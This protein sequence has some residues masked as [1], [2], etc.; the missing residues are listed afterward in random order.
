[1]TGIL[2]A[3][4]QRKY[5]APDGKGR[6]LTVSVWGGPTEQ[7]FLKAVVPVFRALTGANVVFETGSGGERFNKLLAQGSMAT[8]DVFVNSGENVYQA[9]RLGKLLNVDPSLVPNLEDIA[10]WAKLFPYGISYG[11]I[12]FG[13]ARSTGVAS[14]AKLEGSLEAW[15][16]K[17]DWECRLSAILNFR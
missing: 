1:M 14:A 7:A 13:F 11:L 12:A 4:A 8:V 9:N 16:S 10:D 5:S 17:A 15:S 3:A 2:P 6:T